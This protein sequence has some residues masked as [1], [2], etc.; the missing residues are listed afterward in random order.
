MRNSKADKTYNTD[1][2]DYEPELV[3]HLPDRIQSPDRP[4][5]NA[6]FVEIRDLPNGRRAAEAGFGGDTCLIAEQAQPLLA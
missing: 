4:C 3:R 1:H 2:P 5:G 6:P